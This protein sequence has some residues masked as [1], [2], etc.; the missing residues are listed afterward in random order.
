[1]ARRYKG[2]QVR[3]TGPT[4]GPG[5]G[6]AGSPQETRYLECGTGD[7]MKD[8]YTRIARR[9]TRQSMPGDIVDEDTARMYESDEFMSSPFPPDY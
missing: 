3:G 5:D 6:S 1:M 9:R 2:T 4:Y 8:G 7:A